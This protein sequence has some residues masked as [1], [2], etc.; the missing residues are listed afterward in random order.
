MTYSIQNFNLN[1]QVATYFQLDPN[2]GDIRVR[3]PLYNDNSDTQS[4]TFTVVA[5]D[6][7]GRT[8]IQNAQVTINIVR[9]L[10][11]P[12]FTNTPY[13]TT[14]PF[15]AGSQFTVFDVNAT[16]SDTTVSRN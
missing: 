10:F 5:Q 8:S 4:Y 9:N 2:T 16:D 1:S 13:S 11:A 12:Q 15:T 7:E 14:I 3:I 6:G